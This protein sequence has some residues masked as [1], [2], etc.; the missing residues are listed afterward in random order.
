MYKAGSVPLL[1]LVSFRLSHYWYQQRQQKNNG[2]DVYS[3]AM[4]RCPL[5]GIVHV[6]A[7]LGAGVVRGP[8]PMRR[9]SQSRTPL[10]RQRQYITHHAGRY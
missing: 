10:A 7:E 1:A 9:A 5:C 8:L 6:A 3:F 2:R 4:C